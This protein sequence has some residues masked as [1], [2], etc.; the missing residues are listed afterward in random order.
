MSRYQEA[1]QLESQFSTIL[2]NGGMLSVEDIV[3][4]NRISDPSSNPG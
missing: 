2:F 4:E 1:L 3:I